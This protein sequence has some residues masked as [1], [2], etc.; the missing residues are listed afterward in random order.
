MK[1]KRRRSLDR[2]GTKRNL[3]MPFAL[4]NEVVFRTRVEASITNHLRDFA[5]N[6]EKY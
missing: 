6:L 4:S 3:L 5:P 1:N 2:E